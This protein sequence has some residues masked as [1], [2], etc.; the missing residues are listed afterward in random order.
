LTTTTARLPAFR[1]FFE[2]EAVE[3]VRR[4]EQFPR[5]GRMVPEIQDEALRELIHR[6]Y[7]IVYF[8]DA[9]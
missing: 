5:M 8:V 1:R 7:R 4:L 2:D 3:K 6:S 9:E